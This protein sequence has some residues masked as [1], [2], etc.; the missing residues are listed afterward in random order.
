MTTA[1]GGYEFHPALYQNGQMTDLLPKITSSQSY[2]SRA[3]AINQN[4]DVLITVQP[5][6]GAAQSYL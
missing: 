4:G 2:D 3:V 5:I 1:Y 6:G